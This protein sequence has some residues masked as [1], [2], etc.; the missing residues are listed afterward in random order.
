V[1]RGERGALS[2]ESTEW[3]GCGGGEKSPEGLW[4]EWQM[5]QSWGDS[6]GQQA[7]L[8]V[9]GGGPGKCSGGEECG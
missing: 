5:L 1:S 3:T 2:A 8:Y 9:A 6:W 7:G 4:E